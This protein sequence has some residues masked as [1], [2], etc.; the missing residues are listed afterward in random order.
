MK[1]EGEIREIRF[2]LERVRKSIQEKELSDPNKQ[3]SKALDIYM[4]EGA[5]NAINLILEEDSNLT[6]L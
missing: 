3:F 5:I 6:N 2:R 4:L 1:T